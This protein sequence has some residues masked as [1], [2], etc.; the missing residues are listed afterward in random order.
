MSFLNNYLETREH[1]PGT[2]IQHQF[3]FGSQIVNIMILIGI[4]SVGYLFLVFGYILLIFYLY[5]RSH[6]PEF[7][8][9]HAM[10]LFSACLLNLECLIA[11][12]ILL[13]THCH[14]LLSYQWCQWLVFN[15]NFMFKA[16]T[17]AIITKSIFRYLYLT[18]WDSVMSLNV[19]KTSLTII[20]TITGA[21][22]ICE[23]IKFLYHDWGFTAYPLI[24]FNAIVS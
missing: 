15:G 21:S 17:L 8:I 14:H 5:Q 4:V 18:R 3:F 16:M 2:S 24:C 12:L 11:I 22:L 23:L 6:R 1:L 13:L 9:T 10:D 20:A 7:I 19:N